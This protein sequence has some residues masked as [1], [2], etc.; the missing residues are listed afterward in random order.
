[1]ALVWQEI[2]D[3]KGERT[4]DFVRGLG[5]ALSQSWLVAAPAD[6]AETDILSDAAAPK[7]GYAHPRVAGAY[8]TSVS[9]RQIGPFHWVVDAQYRT[10]DHDS[11]QDPQERQGNPLEWIADI[12]WSTTSTRLS[13]WKDI[14]GN[15]I[16]NT[17]GDAFDPPLEVDWNLLVINVKKNCPYVPAWVLTYRNAINSTAW[18]IDGLTVGAKQAKID[19]LDISGWR[20][21]ADWEVAY[22]EVSYRAALSPYP[23]GW[24]PQLLNCGYREK[25]T[26]K[27][28]GE[29]KTVLA[30][31]TINGMSPSNPAPLDAQGKAIAEPSASNVVWLTFQV[32]YE[33]DFNLLPK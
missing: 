9:C 14:W 5:A 1:M 29:D 3:R 6:A 21:N 2:R 17:A 19:G 31:I 18:L 12:Q 11:S 8:C 28:N 4:F 23:D 20:Y 26:I 24:Q 32:Y 27:V 22:R 25:K 16:L 33:L 10:P 7:P 15:P 30:P 13:V